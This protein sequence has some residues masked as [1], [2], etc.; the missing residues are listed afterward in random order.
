MRAKGSRHSPEGL[1][2][3]LGDVALLVLRHLMAAGDLSLTSVS[4]LDRLGR[5]GPA[6]L[7]ELAAAEGVAQPSMTQLVHRLEQMGLA[8]RVRDPGDRRVVLVAVT[9]S[10]RE[11][12]SERRRVHHARLMELLS[13]LP[14]EDRQVLTEA[15][16]TARPLIRQLI[17]NATTPPHR[18]GKATA[19]ATSS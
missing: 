16:Q 8:Q 15:M 13:T 5:H 18:A 2:E 17:L 11:L 3:A 14:T 6:R 4:T 9:D 10:G 1:A 19:S 7:T 12:L